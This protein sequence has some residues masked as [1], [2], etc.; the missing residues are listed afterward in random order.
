GKAGATHAELH[1][2]PLAVTRH[3]DNILPIKNYLINPPET[4]FPLSYTTLEAS[5]RAGLDGNSCFVL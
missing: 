2:K 3:I 1:R 4:L 5:Q